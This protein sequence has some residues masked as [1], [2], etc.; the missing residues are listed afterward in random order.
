MPVSFSEM[1][2]DCTYVVR[3]RELSEKTDFALEDDWLDG[4]RELG[5][6]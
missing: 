6:V 3:G 1:T 4:R 2:A 5:G